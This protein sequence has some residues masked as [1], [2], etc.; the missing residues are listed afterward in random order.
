[1]TIADTRSAHGVVRREGEYWTIS[2]GTILCRLRDAAGLRYLAVL[3]GRPSQ[4]VPA[5]E[6]VRAW[7]RASEQRHE[8]GAGNQSLL[9]QRARFTL[10]QAQDRLSTTREAE[11]ARVTVTRSLRA[12]MQRIAVHNPQLGEH[13]AATIKTGT[14][15]AYTPDARLLVAWDLAPQ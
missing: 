1:M 11:R 10:R 5:T 14:C 15:C 8:C 2:Y 4:S 7:R 3:L 12:V 9:P 6:L 13:L